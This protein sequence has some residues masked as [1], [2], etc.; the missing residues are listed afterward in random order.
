MAPL[1]ACITH[2]IE[3][4]EGCR[5]MP[6]QRP[7]ASGNSSS[8]V[9]IAKSQLN[10]AQAYLY[11]PKITEVRYWKEQ[12]N[13]PRIER[14]SQGAK[15]KCIKIWGVQRKLGLCKLASCHWCYMQNTSST[16]YHEHTW[17]SHWTSRSPKGPDK[18]HSDVEFGLQ[19]TACSRGRWN[20]WWSLTCRISSN[21]LMKVYLVPQQ[22]GHKP[23]AYNKID[24]EY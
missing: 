3:A 17:T 5:N 18:A 10:P 22:E 12:G 13:N 2:S 19:D 23:N 8:I 16:E 20:S 4:W 1:P 15:H 9:P 7:L 14:G 21:I 11:F 6:S 24:L